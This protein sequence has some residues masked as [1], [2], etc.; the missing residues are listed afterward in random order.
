[1][2]VKNSGIYHN[3]ISQLNKVV[4]HNNS[5]LNVERHRFGGV[6]RTW[7][8]REYNLMVLECMKAGRTD[9]EACLV[10]T[11]H[12]GLRI[13]EIMRLDTAIAHNSLKT[14]VLM[15]K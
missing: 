1:M 11:R 9:Y 5:R 10:I 12:C 13:H 7:S 3:L 8:N 14:N 4:R 2:K 15:I 6:D